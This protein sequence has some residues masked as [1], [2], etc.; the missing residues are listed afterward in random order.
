ML[1]TEFSYAGKS[2]ELEIGPLWPRVL[3]NSQKP[4]SWN[5]AFKTGYNFD[6]IVTLGAGIDFLWNHN[7]KDENLGG[8]IY[9]TVTS[10]RTYMFPISGFFSLT[11]LP[12]LKVQPCF[13]AQVGFNTM[14]FSHTE[15][16]V[17]LQNGNNHPIIDENGWY[18]GMYWKI[19]ADVLLKLSK[20]SG[21]F[22]G[23]AYQWTRPTKL[24]LTAKDIFARR[25]MSGIGIRVGIKAE[26]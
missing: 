23:V 22:T 24:D 17:G 7:N 10:E 16:S 6:N 15:D 13:S 21:I 20:N 4:T 19:A 9:K 3:L 2:F 12:D 25:D 18:M 8:N 1:L 26:L 11:P 5:T 14:Y